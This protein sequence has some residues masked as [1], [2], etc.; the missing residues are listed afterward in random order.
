VKVLTAAEM[1]EVDRR[2]I[3]LGISG[4]VL[5]ENAG[6]RVI[7]FLT[8]RFA[9]LSA[10]RVV[11]VCGKGNNGGDGLVIARQLFTR[12]RPASLHVIVSDP[13]DQSE[14]MRM[15]RA[16]GFDAVS[17]KVR[18]EMRLASLVIDAVLGTGLSGPARGRALELIRE[19]NTG[20]PLAKVVAVDIP[21]GMPSDG[22]PATGEVARADAT[23]TFTAPKVAHVLYGGV[24]ELRVGHIGSATSL[25]EYVQLHVTEPAEFRV[26]LAPRAA[27]SN[28]GTYGHVLV[29]GGNTG[30]TGAAE[31][32]GFAAL[33]TGA[34]LVTVACAEQRLA[35]PELM[36]ASLPHD[37]AALT[38]IASRKDVIAVG[39]GL[40]T[41]AESGELVMRIVESCPQPVVIDADGL[42][43]V[44]DAN[45]Q[46]GE[47]LRI[48]TPHPGE[49]SRLAGQTI[50]D[51]QADRLAVARAYAA[52]RGAVV[53]LKGD[54]TV[55]A[56]PD[57]RAWVN[58]T[59]TPAMATGGTGDVLTGMIAGMLAQYPKDPHAAVLAAVYLHGLAGEIGA[60]ELGDKCL[61]ATDLLRYLPEAMHA[62]AARL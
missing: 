49:M 6:H 18:A 52:Q 7:E 37:S 46:A 24:G 31:M 42:N 45:W 56:L 44:A 38:A 53:V 57:R 5:M 29:V 36:T 4:A 15:L 43:V 33:R 40:G 47:R 27:E 51:V 35:V 8:E 50:A 59:G 21:S 9:P 34:G 14:P 11:I 20:F 61:I 55:I 2:T 60:R 13:A 12:F 1:R 28:K 16:T 19:I 39:P 10:Q 26:V 54:R 23:V 41:D 32:A 30:K 3:E 25:Y 22:E 58:P 62:A 17:G 48:L